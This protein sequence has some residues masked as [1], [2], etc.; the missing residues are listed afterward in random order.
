VTGLTRTLVPA[1]G[2]LVAAGALAGACFGVLHATLPRQSKG[3]G[4]ATR[5][6]IALDRWRSHGAV[7]RIGGR[8]LAV[9]CRAARR[10]T[11]LDYADGTRLLVRGRRVHPLRTPETARERLLATATPADPEL[12][13]A[14][15][16]LGGSRSLYSA[17]LAVRLSVGGEPLVDRTLLDGIPAYVLRL[18]RKGIVKLVVAQATLTP[19]AVRYSSARL[20]GTSRLLTAP[21]RGLAAVGSGGC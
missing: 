16:V 14:E 13:A 11:I 21:A 1:L 10:G 12:T 18:G 15:A 9:T 7:V 2:A 6:M 4:I 5:T 8:S 3:Q 19:L 20:H 17:G